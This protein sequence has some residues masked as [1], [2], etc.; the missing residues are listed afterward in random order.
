MSGRGGTFTV[1]VAPAANDRMRDHFDFLARVSEAAAI[2]LVDELV[3]DIRSLER[4]PFRC[5]CF[6][7]AGIKKGKYRFLISAKRYRVVYQISGDTVFVDD[8]QDCRQDSDKNSV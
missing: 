6:E 3:S 2:Q 5:P 8:I 7:R 4:S 1:K